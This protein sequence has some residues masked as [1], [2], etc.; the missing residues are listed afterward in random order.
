MSKSENKPR[1]EVIIGP[2][3]DVRRR[4]PRPVTDEIDDQTR[5]G[6]VYL[7]SLIRTQ[8]LLGLATVALVVV[9]L[10][11][12]PL[13]FGWWPAARSLQVGPLPLWWLIL[14]ILVYPAILGVGWWYVRQADRNEAQ[15]TDLVEGR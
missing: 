10:I 2:R 3:R 4:P 12:M 9:P 6:K 11:A 7:R 1:R 8:L 14:G 5:V 15:F 13:I